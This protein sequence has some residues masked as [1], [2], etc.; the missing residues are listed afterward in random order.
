MKIS[1]LVEELH[2]PEYLLLAA[3]RQFVTDEGQ[4]LS[5]VIVS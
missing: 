1:L 2:H 5:F 3:P 4:I